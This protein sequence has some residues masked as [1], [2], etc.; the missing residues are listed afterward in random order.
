MY[1]RPNVHPFDPQFSSSAHVK[2]IASIISVHTHLPIMR[3]M[4]FSNSEIPNKIGKAP[5]GDLM[6]R[7]PIQGSTNTIKSQQSS[8][9]LSNGPIENPPFEESELF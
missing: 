1:H 6:T 2:T 7:S 9:D 4:H 3:K 5:A 8:P